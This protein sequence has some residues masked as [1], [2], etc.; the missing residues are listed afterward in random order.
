MTTTSVMP[1]GLVSAAGVRLSV[2]IEMITPEL[3]G[4]YLAANGPNRNP[5]RIS[6]A[7]YTRDMDAD[8]WHLTGET[9]IF[10]ASGRL[11]NGQGRLQACINADKPFE[12]LVVRGV[13]NED[14]VM[15]A[16]DSG[17]K[18]TLAHTLQIKG[19]GDP[20]RLASVINMV[21]RYEQHRVRGITWPS[22]DE[23]DELYEANKAL[24]MEAV[25]LTRRVA[26]SL[27]LPPGPT[28]AAY[29]LN[30]RADELAAGEFWEKVGSG[31]GLLTGDPILAYRSWVITKLSQREKAMPEVW[32]KVNMKVMREWRA[33]HS[34]KL[35]TVQPSE[36]IAEPW[37]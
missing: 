37:A 36:V 29:V 26:K 31:E 28:G 19:I 14:I 2:A 4:T 1:Q 30:A 11:L 10:G 32:I 17:R 23:G 6:V 18:R 21:W 34:M 16:L 20:N 35:V 12:T 3:A 27:A 8:R 9:L 25:R 24:L 5:D 13:E 33:G 15:H 22:N 7:R